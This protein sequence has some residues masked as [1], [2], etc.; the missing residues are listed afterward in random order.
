LHANQRRI[1][2][3]QRDTMKHPIGTSLSLALL[4]T[5]I[6]L[7]ALAADLTVTMY[8]ATQDGTGATIGTV[9]I[10][11]SDAGATFKLSLHG[12]PP[13]PHGFL[14]HE[15]ADC[16]P[17][18]INGIR[19]PAG[20]AGAPLDP[21][22][23]GKHEGPLGQ[24]YLGDLPVLTVEADGAVNQTLTAPRIKNIDVLKGHALIIHIGG[25]NYSDTPNLVGGTAGRLA[26]GLIR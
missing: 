14:V 18:F 3:K 21:D 6:A 1:E 17:T 20:A 4:A 12:L 8:K 2:G 22:N 25:D 10:S 26:C 19:I 11:G 15:N 23:T 24:G 13:G 7:P 16:G 5:V 9:T